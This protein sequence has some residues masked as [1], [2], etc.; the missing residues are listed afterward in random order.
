MMRRKKTETRRR[1]RRKKTVRPV[2]CVQRGQHEA[3]QS[4]RPSRAATAGALRRRPSSLAGSQLCAAPWMRSAHKSAASRAP[5]QRRAS[6]R[7]CDSPTRIGP[8][9]R[10]AARPCAPA[11][12]ALHSWRG[13]EAAALLVRS[14]CKP[15]GTSRSFRL[16][17]AFALAFAHTRTHSLSRSR[18]RAAIKALRMGQLCHLS[19]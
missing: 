18:S 4:C 15:A 13:E 5:A 12:C 10:A 19:N 14:L 2:S 1:M 17:L 11:G 3:A 6:V 8:R 16:S 7:P 9:V